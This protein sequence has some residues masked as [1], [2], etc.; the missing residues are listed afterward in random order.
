MSANE[1]TEAACSMVHTRVGLAVR[2]VPTMDLQ[3]YLEME[4]GEA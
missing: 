3:T 1:L 4:A 2:Q